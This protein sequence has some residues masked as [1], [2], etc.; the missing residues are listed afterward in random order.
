MI[1][2]FSKNRYIKQKANQEKVK[3]IRDLFI[4]NP[5]RWYSR[6]EI[7][8]ISNYTAIRTVINQLRCEGLSII[9]D[10]DKGYKLTNN[11]KEVRKCYDELRDR[12][13][14]AITAAK[15]MKKQL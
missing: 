1:T 10:H 5:E 14:R 2:I 9:S 11:K 8:I 12:A 6:Y 4:S 3:L 7:E 15:L 13:L